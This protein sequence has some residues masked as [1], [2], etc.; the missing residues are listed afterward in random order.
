LTV[1]EALAALPIANGLT[2]LLKHLV[3]EH[4]PYQEL[5]GVIPR[6]ADNMT[7]SFGTASAHSANM[8]AIAFVFCYG[9]DWW[10]VPWAVA[11][12]LT[13]ISR[14]Y[15]G[16]HYPYQ[17]LLGWACGIFAGIVVTKAW[18][19]IVRSRKSVSNTEGVHKPAET[20]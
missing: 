3:P 1:L 9:L 11:A 13:G 20:A 19:L 4:R 5:A 6:P 10:G 7:L 18:E 14:V 15:V 17:V 2:D 8:A 12:L 16:A